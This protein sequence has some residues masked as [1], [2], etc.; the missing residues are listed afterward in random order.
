M[1]PPE[2]FRVLAAAQEASS[3]ADVGQMI[4]GFAQYGVVGVIVVLLIMGIVVPKYVM[5][6]LTADRDNWRDAFEKEREGHQLTRQ[7][8]AA[9]QAS[10]E[11]A[12]E[13]GQAMV[14]LLEEFGH[15]PHTA[16]RSV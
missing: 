2:L 11:V 3:G 15:Q 16:P 14:R 6:G 1:V 7:Q 13:Q 12:N 4:G 5:N 9:A 8:L 10:A